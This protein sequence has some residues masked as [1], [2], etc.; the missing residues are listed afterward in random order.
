[1]FSNLKLTI[2]RKLSI[3]YG[4]LI[5]AILVNVILTI[6]ITTRNSRL[7]NM[8]SNTY[9]PAENNLKQLSNLVV[10]SKMLIKNWVFIEKKSDTPDKIKLKDLQDKEFPKIKGILEELTR[11][12]KWTDQEKN[13][14]KRIS[15][16][17]ETLFA[18]QKEIMNSLNTFES[19]NDPNVIFNLNPLVEEGGAVM[20]LTDQ[21]LADLD[22]LTLSQTQKADN[23]RAAMN[24][25]FSTFV[26]F[27]AITGVLLIVIALIVAFTTVISIVN[28]LKKG[29]EF[30]KALGSGDLMSTV[31]IN[32]KDEIGELADSLKE[33]VAK[34]RETVIKIVNG[35][36]KIATTGNEMNHRAQQ[37]SQGATDQASSTEEVSSSMEEMVSNI[38]QNTENSQQT[39]KIAITASNGIKR[40]REAATE[41]VHSIQAI[42]E[43][44]TIVNDIAFQT[45]ILA[46]NAAVEAARAGEH[47]KGFAVV[48]AEVRKLA[49]R[50][51]V[52]ADEIQILAKNSVSATEEAGNLLFE[53][54]PE[55]ER[56][57]KLVQEITAAS[58]EQNSG[59]DQIN[60]SI[61]QLNQITQQNA[62]VSDEMTKNAKALT[63]YADE[64]RSVTTF[65]KVDH[66][67]KKEE[68]SISKT[69]LFSKVTAKP[70]I[71]TEK[72]STIAPTEELP[73]TKAKR[74]TLPTSKGINLNMYGGD[75]SDSDYER[76]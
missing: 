7:N 66:Q 20:V 73:K 14:F 39:E 64:L 27:I 41:S 25:S 5:F 67:V 38:Q 74:S 49:E 42:A 43:K 61:Q 30:A 21:I 9:L 51:K 45:N 23:A 26:K 57:A 15:T 32:Q 33:M 1:M 46:L 50:S 65:F 58:I 70:A 10:N 54:A 69:N 75:N 22:K 3:G 29:V 71:K 8:I 11:S 35:A 12:D 40:V 47:G 48:A 28:P 13:D 55:I 63:D 68:K 60:N 44:I 36:E 76:F 59:V 17:I 2:G 56:T 37:L 34:I 72:P 62:V 52:A 31:D 19:Y 53:L 4:I 24:T 18:K 6:V 16:S